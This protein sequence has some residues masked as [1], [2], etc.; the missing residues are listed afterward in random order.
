MAR[1]HHLLAAADKMPSNLKALEY[2]ILQRL[3]LITMH[4]EI[5]L[6][7]HMSKTIQ[8]NQTFLAQGTNERTGK[9]RYCQRLPGGLA[10]TLHLLG[11]EVPAHSLLIAQLPPYTCS[12]SDFLLSSCLL[13]QASYTALQ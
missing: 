10:Y 3:L 4:K 13:Y 8:I 9:T 6:T 1:Y 5:F 2:S 12:L 11:T 7:S